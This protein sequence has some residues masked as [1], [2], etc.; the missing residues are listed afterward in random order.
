MSDYERTR[1][2]GQAMD[3]TMMAGGGR[4]QMGGTFECPVCRATAS[5]LDVF[6][7]EC[8][9]RFGGV[10]V[11][12]SD[13][14]D[15]V[16][17]YIICRETRQK[18]PLHEGVNTVGRVNSDVTINDATVSRN[19][20][21][22]TIHSGLIVLEDLG[23]SNGTKVDNDRVL[24]GASTPVR[25]GAKLRFGTWRAVLQITSAGEVSEDAEDAPPPPPPPVPEKKEKTIQAVKRQTPPSY[26]E[27]AAQN[28]ALSGLLDY[29]Y[30][31]NALQNG[32]SDD[33]PVPVASA[34]PV[35]SSK[36]VPLD[37]AFAPSSS[38]HRHEA[39]VSGS[40]FCVD[41]DAP[42]IPVME[43]SLSIGRKVGNDIVLANDSFVSGRHALIRHDDTGTYLIDVGSTNGTVVNGARVQANQPVLLCEGDEIQLGKNRFIFRL[44]LDEG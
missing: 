37:E 41:G 21:K 19:H 14:P 27:V 5:S 24:A 22:I 13:V 15:E 7:P 3:P 8:G 9:F 31:S 23:S 16:V 4:T 6:C 32:A 34:P 43:G 38:P 11:F 17:A 42:D 12:E 33:A 36:P 25:H 20:A 39:G 10:P 26:E 29:S 40:L 28:V 44:A 30:V 2:A 35:P 18:Y 1:L